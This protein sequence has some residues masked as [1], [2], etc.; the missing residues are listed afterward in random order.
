MAKTRQQ[1]GPKK[2][3]APAR[4]RRGASRKR[5]GRAPKARGGLDGPL[6][7]LRRQAQA[8]IQRLQRVG[9]Q[10]IG[11]IEKQIEALNRQRQALMDELSAVVRGVGGAGRGAKGARRGRRARV[12]WNE[13]Y[14]NLPRGSFK[15]SDVRKIV[16]SVA[17]GTLSQRLTAWVKA[18]KLRRSGSRRGTRYTRP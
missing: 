13:V 11:A 4:A 5:P 17:A 3:R 18:R 16:P 12:D 15:A 2:R 7:D 9:W 6:G 8:V 14:G 10:R 1:T